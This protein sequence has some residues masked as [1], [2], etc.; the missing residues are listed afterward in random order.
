M[1]VFLVLHNG[2]VANIQKNVTDLINIHCMCHRL[3]LACVDT[4]K[5]L[6]YL[7]T[8]EKLLNQVSYCQEESKESQESSSSQVAFTQGFSASYEAR[9]CGA[10]YCV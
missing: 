10:Y 6:T 9:V 2:I 5:D 3:A 4:C 1:F 7:L 8:V